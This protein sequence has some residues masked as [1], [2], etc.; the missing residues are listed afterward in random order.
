[1][2]LGVLFLFL[3]LRR[4]LC[5]INLSLRRA[6][7]ALSEAIS[8]FFDKSFECAVSVFRSEAACSIWVLLMDSVLGLSCASLLVTCGNAAVEVK[9]VG[10]IDWDL[11]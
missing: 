11:P 8:N 7:S 4:D 2:L 1:M 3:C 6:F 9:F 10:L 5:A